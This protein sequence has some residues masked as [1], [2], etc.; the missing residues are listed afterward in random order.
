[1]TTSKQTKRHPVFVAIDIAKA[2][3]QVLIE[4]PNGKRSKVAIDNSKADSSGW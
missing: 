3:H 2:R 1:M 4:D